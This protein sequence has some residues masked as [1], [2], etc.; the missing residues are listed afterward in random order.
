MHR[1]RRI[2]AVQIAKRSVCIEQYFSLQVLKQRVVFTE[3]RA[4][5]LAVYM[6]HLNKV[7]YFLRQRICRW[8]PS[9]SLDAERQHVR[10]TWALNDALM[11]SLINMTIMV[12]KYHQKTCTCTYYNLN[13]NRHFSFV[14]T[15]HSF[16]RITSRYNATL[17]TTGQ[18]VL[19]IDII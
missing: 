19:C 13:S 14:S 16:S 4:E 5:S 10:C 1:T 9:L 17:L 8:T 12:I 2:C 7:F 15:R 3:R 6:P 11:K 18:F